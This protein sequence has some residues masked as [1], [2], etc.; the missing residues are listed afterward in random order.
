M[1]YEVGIDCFD[2]NVKEVL[3]DC[4][5]CIIRIYVCLN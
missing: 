5:F 2:E 3:I 4:N 1:N